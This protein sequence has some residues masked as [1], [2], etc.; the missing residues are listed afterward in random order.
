MIDIKF[1][2]LL[3]F[4]IL[5]F[6]SFNCT[7]SKRVEINNSLGIKIPDNSKELEYYKV[8][9]SVDYERPY[10]VYIKF[11]VDSI[12][13]DEVI[14]K[15]NLISNKNDFV[16]S[17]CLENIDRFFIKNLWSFEFGNFV[18]SS[19][20]LKRKLS[21]W[22]PNN[23]RDILLYASFYREDAIKKVENCYLK[24]WDGRILLSYNKKE[25]NIYI[26]IEV[27]MEDESASSTVGIK[28]QSSLPH[29]PLTVERTNNAATK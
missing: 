20:I 18:E 1:N 13:L 8:R 22:N 24:E 12:G 17:M 7:K 21:W 11:K 15:T 29:L 6:T 19:D 27:Y 2:N 23:G 16:K 9:R 25:E 26:F 28:L 14:T 10:N 4:C 3:L 5:I